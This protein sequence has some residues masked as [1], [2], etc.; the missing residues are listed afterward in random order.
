M[1]DHILCPMC[2]G[3]IPGKEI[4]S[5]KTCPSC[6]ADLSALVR[7]RLAEEARAMTPPPRPNPFISQAGLFS[8]IAPCVA[9][10]VYLFGRRASSDNPNGMLVAGIVCLLVAAVGLMFGVVAFFAPKGQEG[11][12]R[13]K[14]EEAATM[15]KAI[16]GIFLNGLLITFAIFGTT[17]QNVAASE[18]PTPDTPR[19]GSSY[20]SGR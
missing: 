5:L 10:V 4:H 2:Q 11:E 18:N 3:A 20:L 15:A 14:E 13:G 6:G 19:K 8:L 12:K 9:I 16:A 1:V 7:R 17:R